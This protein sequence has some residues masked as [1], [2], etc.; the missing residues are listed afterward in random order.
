M[1]LRQY[2]TT[3][4]VLLTGK[5][6]REACQRC[7][8][9]KFWENTQSSS[10]STLAQLSHMNDDLHLLCQFYRFTIFMKYYFGEDEKIEIIQLCYTVPVTPV[11]ALTSPVSDYI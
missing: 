10:T 1:N 5:R 11:F 6:F 7:I 3:L 4:Q 2:S 8:K 9:L